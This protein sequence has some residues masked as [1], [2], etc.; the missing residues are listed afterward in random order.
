M[1]TGHFSGERDQP[2]RIENSRADQRLLFAIDARQAPPQDFRH[3]TSKFACFAQHC[4]ILMADSASS[5]ASSRHPEAPSNWA[6]RRVTV[7]G[8]GRHGG[9]LGA[10]K[11]LVSQGA[12]VTIS[13]HASDKL[14]APTL[15]QLA[16][17]S[18]EAV[19]LG[20][21]DAR[22]FDR[23]DAVLVNPAVP[24][25]HELLTRV[26]R[27]GV[28]VTSEIELCL[29]YC[30]APIVGITGSNGKSTTVMMTT[31]VLRAGG[32]NAW[33]GG[34]LG[35][36]L[37]PILD[38]IRENDWVVLELSSFQLAHLN[39]DAPLPK[40]GCITNCTPNHLDW[41]GSF[42]NYAQ[43]KQRLLSAEQVFVGADQCDLSAAQAC[44]AQAASS[45]MNLPVARV[46]ETTKRSK[47]VWPD[48]RLP[49]LL[50][51]GVHNRANAACAA[52]IAHVV[53]ID[54]QTIQTALARFQ[55]L[56]HRLQ[57]VGQT[58]GRFFFNDSKSTSPAATLAALAAMSTPVWLLVG[59]I[60]KGVDFGI[61]AAEMQ[62]GTHGIACFG[63][64]GPLLRDA[65]QK[66]RD[67][68]TVSCHE[69]LA[70]AFSWCWR[71]SAPG[72]TILLSPA[73]ASWDQFTDFEDRG[74]AFCT[75][76][77]ALDR[78]DIGS[79]LPNH[80]AK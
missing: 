48:E 43:A 58:Q 28:L 62:H 11:F 22:D 34:N 65:L 2:S 71:Q 51:P 9:G 12:S 66:A 29:R 50:V 59:G 49:E 8:L 53:G 5:Q 21:H 61:F 33:A 4:G 40:I 15:E 63:T 46:P 30:R 27:R 47:P 25:N 75:L 41:H 39:H 37:L 64:D 42:E 55:G 36:S 38:Q 54:D 18:L 10:V 70:D 13:D 24:P 77:A 76:V 1:P 57:F 45:S 17:L 80:R 68:Q 32:I 31:H 79:D 67:Q 6:G 56:D 19:H 44:H 69:T 73:C 26:R 35:G 3:R 20:G 78:P 23:C 16:G 60:A 7:I 74:R 52:S 72:D 14:L